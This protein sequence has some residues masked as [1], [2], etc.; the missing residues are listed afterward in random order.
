MV[1]KLLEGEQKKLARSR[2]SQPVARLA[3]DVTFSDGI[4][5]IAKPTDPNRR[6]L[7]AIPFIGKHFL[8]DRWGRR[9]VL[10]GRRDHDVI[11]TT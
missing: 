5:V 3:L 1:F 8:R 2:R 6:R 10:L 7:T 9:Q 4:E 11:G